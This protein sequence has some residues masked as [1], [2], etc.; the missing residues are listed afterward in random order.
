MGRRAMATSE[1]EQRQRRAAENQSLFREVNERIEHILDRFEL[2]EGSMLDFMCECAH[3]ECS[4]RL[5]M[6]HA[7]YEA[8]RRV[9]THFAVK[10]GHEIPDVEATVQTNDRYVVVAKFGAAGQEAINL[11]PRSRTN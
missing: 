7:E 9:P 4:E 2:T 8:M 11:D 6:T 10:A 5:E 1:I 3:E